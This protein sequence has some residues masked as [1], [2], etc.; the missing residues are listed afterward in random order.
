MFRHKFSC[1]IPCNRIILINSLVI[2]LVVVRDVIMMKIRLP[3]LDCGFLLLLGFMLILMSIAL[4]QLPRRVLFV[5]SH[6]FF[7]YVAHHQGKKKTVS[8]NNYHGQIASAFVASLYNL[9]LV[10][11]SQVISKLCIKHSITHECRYSKD[12]KQIDPFELSYHIFLTRFTLCEHYVNN[13]HKDTN[14]HF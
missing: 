4:L 11:D 9:T 3:I 12:V 8:I 13:K 1:H 10:V 5:V 6:E 7:A 2:G 14:L